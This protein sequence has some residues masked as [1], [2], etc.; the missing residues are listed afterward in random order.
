MQLSPEMATSSGRAAPPMPEAAVEPHDVD[1]AVDRR[2]RRRIERAHDVDGEHESHAVTILLGILVAATF[3][4][5]VF[6]FVMMSNTI[7]LKWSD[8]GWSVLVAL[9][10]A[11]I[12]ALAVLIVGLIT[13]ANRKSTTA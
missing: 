8:L 3:A 6:L 5:I 11:G 4:A 9:A 7:D 1:V 13:R 2:Y 12:V 10:C